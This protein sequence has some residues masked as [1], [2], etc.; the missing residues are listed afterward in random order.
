MQSAISEQ[1]KSAAAE[2]ITSTPTCQASSTFVTSAADRILDILNTTEELPNLD[3]PTKL[4]H[5][6]AN[7]IILLAKSTDVATTA[8]AHELLTLIDISLALDAKNEQNQPITAV[9]A[10][11]HICTLLPTD[12]LLETFLPAFL[13]CSNRM[14]LLTQHNTLRGKV[15]PGSRLIVLHNIVAPRIAIRNNE[16]SQLLLGKFRAFIL[17]AFL[18]SD[19]LN[20]GHDWHSR[21]LS[22]STGPVPDPLRITISDLSDLHHLTVLEMFVKDMQNRVVSSSRSRSRTHSPRYIPLISNA[23]K[24][25]L[26]TSLAAETMEDTDFAGT[27]VM[28]IKILL[29]FVLA[30][31]S[32]TLAIPAAQRARSNDITSINMSPACVRKAKYVLNQ[33]TNYFK[34]ASGVDA[35]VPS[36]RVADA[37]ATVHERTFNTMKASTFAHPS[38]TALAKFRPLASSTNSVQSPDIQASKFPHKLGTPGISKAWRTSTTMNGYRVKRFAD[39]AER[40]SGSDADDDGD[41]E[42]GDDAERSR[43]QWKHYRATRELSWLEMCT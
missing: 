21:P 19:K 2:S 38:L 35:A 16:T 11:V 18:I 41:K 5:V 30:V 17:H 31:N 43:R 8:T 3:I 39:I 37:L 4:N 15:K 36:P 1:I 10:L 25:D 27:A 29:E 42:A 14:H 40:T 23:N 22:L 9:N 33:I 28:Q 34:L 20:R 32:G 26:W 24:V 12:A 7:H 6:L 13:A